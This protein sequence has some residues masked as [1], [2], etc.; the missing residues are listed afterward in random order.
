M[1][2]Q[3]GLRATLIGI[4]LEP[5]YE[6][7]GEWKKLEESL[8]RRNEGLRILSPTHFL[9]R[10]LLSIGVATASWLWLLG[11]ARLGLVTVNTGWV[12]LAALLGLAIIEHLLMVFTLPLQRLWGWAMGPKADGA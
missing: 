12:L 6:A 2:V 7:S 3:G 9:S 8:R 10:H 11:E 1:A 4:S 5:A